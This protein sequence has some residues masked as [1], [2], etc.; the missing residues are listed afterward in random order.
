[1]HTHNT[2]NE[3]NSI[4]LKAKIVWAFITCLVALMLQ[5]IRTQCSGPVIADTVF[6]WF[7]PDPQANRPPNH[8]AWVRV[9]E[10]V[11]PQWTGR[12]VF[13]C[14]ASWC[15]ANVKCECEH[16][17]TG[18]NKL[19]ILRNFRQWSMCHSRSA[20]R[21]GTSRWFQSPNSANSS[22]F[23]APLACGCMRVRVRVYALVFG[24]EFL[25]N[26]YLSRCQSMCACVSVFVQLSVCL[27]LFLHSKIP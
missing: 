13:S 25:A 26:V 19:Q 17:A 9:A 8:C 11:R 10:W 27:A 20:H 12:P 24:V 21:I 23:S 14:F 22:S 15:V 3:K 16:F 6:W 4:R 1:M 7:L 2:I 18:I 5:T